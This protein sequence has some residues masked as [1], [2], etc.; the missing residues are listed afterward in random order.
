MLIFLMSIIFFMHKIL[1]ENNFVWWFSFPTAWFTSIIHMID[2][3]KKTSY[4]RIHHLWIRQSVLNVHDVIV[5]DVTKTY[6]YCFIT[7]LGWLLHTVAPFPFVAPGPLLPGTHK[8]YDRSKFAEFAMMGSK[9]VFLCTRTL[10]S[11]YINIY[12]QHFPIFYLW[13]NQLHNM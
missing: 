12:S 6:L 5:M 13:K 1:D 10:R 2:I 11:V 7:T 9:F 4:C 3:L 8:L